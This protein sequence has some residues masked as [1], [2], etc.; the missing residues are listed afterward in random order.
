VRNFL[1]SSAFHT[2]YIVSATTHCA[3]TVDSEHIQSVTKYI[4][5]THSS[6]KC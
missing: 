2:A 4:F 5:H 6:Y 1:V 3:P